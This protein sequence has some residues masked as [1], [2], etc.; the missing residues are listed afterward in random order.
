MSITL[1]SPKDTAEL[2]REIIHSAPA[3]REHAYLAALSGDLGAGKTTLTQAVARELGV[4]EAVTSPTFVIERVY[5]LPDKA[6]FKRLVHIDA[7]RL[8][9]GREL[10]ALGWDE[11]LARSDDLI[12]LEWPERVAEVLP[13]DTVYL[14]LEIVNEKE[15]RVRWK[16]PLSASDHSRAVV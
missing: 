1:H 5:Q 12:L 2:A 14:D 4:I 16:T 9:S 11:T 3:K 7:Y 8:E 13:N 6:P 10:L 15:R